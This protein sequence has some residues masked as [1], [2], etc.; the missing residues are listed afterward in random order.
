LAPH[1]GY[2]LGNHAV[3]EIGS[4]NQWAHIVKSVEW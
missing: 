4:G 1:N 3:T 2:D